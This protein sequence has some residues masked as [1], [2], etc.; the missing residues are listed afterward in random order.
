M[1]QMCHYTHRLMTIGT[2]PRLRLSFSDYAR[3]SGKPTTTARN[4][5]PRLLSMVKFPISVPISPCKRCRDR[6]RVSALR[7]ESLNLSK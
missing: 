7:R 6:G 4:N 1:K 3:T 5:G 2:C